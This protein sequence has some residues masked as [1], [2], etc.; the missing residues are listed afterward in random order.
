MIYGKILRSPHAHARIVSVDTSAAEKAPGV[1]ATLVWKQP[2]AKVMYQGDEVAAVAADTEERAL[3][4]VRLIKVEYATLPHLASVDQA[5]SA[6]APAVFEGGNTKVGVTQ[7]TGDPEAGFKEAV[8]VV[9]ATYS[10]HVIT[11]ICL[12]TA[13]CVCRWEG[14]KLT[15][16]VSTRRHGTAQGFAQS[17]RFRS[18]TSA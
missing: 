6:D 14:D 3:D 5:L 18:P 4:A 12:E 11:H 10:T 15:A 9:D 1:K 13:R 8:Q 16:W 7:E 17:L 2:G